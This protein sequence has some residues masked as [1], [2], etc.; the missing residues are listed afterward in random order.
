MKSVLLL[1]LILQTFLYIHV[2]LKGTCKPTETLLLPIGPIICTYGKKPHQNRCS[3]K[4]VTPFESKLHLFKYRKIVQIQC[5]KTFDICKILVRLIH[6]LS[7]WVVIFWDMVRSFSVEVRLNT[8]ITALTLYRLYGFNPCTL[9]DPDL[10]TTLMCERKNIS[11]DMMYL[12]VLRHRE[13][14]HND[15]LAKHKVVN[16]D[17]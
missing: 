8:S 3:N 7:S 12:S 2:A 11:T 4:D 1:C 13:E 10:S 5:P 14:K 6:W 9:S 17:R 16:R 15:I